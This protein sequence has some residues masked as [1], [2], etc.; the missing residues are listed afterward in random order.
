MKNK[1]KPALGKLIDP[2][3]SRMGYR[4]KDNAA[5]DPLEKFFS[6]LQSLGFAPGHIVDVGANHGNWTRTAIKYFPNAS[7]TL[8]EPQQL[9]EKYFRD[10][11]Q[12]NPKIRF[13]PV[14]AGSQSGSFKF[15]ITDRDDSSTFRATTEQAA[16]LGLQQIDVPVTTLNELMQIHDL[17]APD[18]IK[19]DAEG[20]DVEVLKGASHFFGITEVFMV[21]AGVVS[22]DIANSIL[23]VINYMDRNAYRL[24]DITDLNRPQNIKVLWLVELVFVRKSGFLDSK[25]FE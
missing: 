21:E 16:R 3:F 8:V 1:L 18:L 2:L 23:K 6:M 17:P 7:Y 5:G 11:L 10:L 12:S 13:F 14:G 9:L 19:I 4:K 20:L 22:K 25:F 15:T 24:F